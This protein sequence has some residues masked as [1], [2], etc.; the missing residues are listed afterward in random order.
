MTEQ[1]TTEAGSIDGAASALDAGLER[2][3]REAGFVYEGWDSAYYWTATIADIA[4][5]AALVAAEEREACAKL[6][7]ALESLG[8]KMHE[9]AKTDLTW[10]KKWEAVAMDIDELLRSNASLSGRGGDVT[11]K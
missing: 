6:R 2:L 4:K 7:S 1:A 3:A 8:R 9:R 5:F 11:T 10:H